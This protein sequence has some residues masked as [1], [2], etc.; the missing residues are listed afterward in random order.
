MLV[1]GGP[2]LGWIVVLGTFFRTRNR[3][4]KARPARA[5][6][7]KKLKESLRLDVS[8]SFHI[9]LDKLSFCFQAEGKVVTCCTLGYRASRGQRGECGCRTRSRTRTR[10]NEDW[11]RPTP[12]Q[13]SQI[14]TVATGKLTLLPKLA[15]HNLALYK[16][17][18][19]ANFLDIFSKTMAL[20][21]ISDFCLKRLV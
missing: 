11:H 21:S 9:W 17:N 10:S 16:L 8:S 14:K 12:E 5:V 15:S 6:D 20:K 19:L 4:H 7:D 1:R 2:A 18:V 13:E 3:K